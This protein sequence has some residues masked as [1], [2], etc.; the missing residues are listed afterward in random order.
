MLCRRSIKSSTVGGWYGGGAVITAKTSHQHVLVETINSSLRVI[1]SVTKCREQNYAIERHVSNYSHM[2][3]SQWKQVIRPTSF[4]VTVDD[5]RVW[6]W[7]YVKKNTH[8]IVLCTICIL[9]ISYKS[10][11]C[12]LEFVWLCVLSSLSVLWLLSPACVGSPTGSASDQQS[13][14]CGFE[15]H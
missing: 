15:A 5:D 4:F 9:S 12:C 11:F 7:I 1:L 13:K 10:L 14:G 3:S 6:R 2:H 8:A